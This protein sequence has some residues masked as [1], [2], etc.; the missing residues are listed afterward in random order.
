MDPIDD[1]NL[2]MHV[3]VLQLYITHK[4]T[5][6]CVVKEKS[7]S[8]DVHVRVYNLITRFEVDGTLSIIPFFS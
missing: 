4:Q 2:T 7:I 5:H 8:Q 3:R 1:L 6:V